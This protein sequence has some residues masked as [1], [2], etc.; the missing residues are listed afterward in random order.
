MEDNKRRERVG[1]DEVDELD[2]AQLIKYSKVNFKKIEFC[3]RSN[4][5]LERL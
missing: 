1:Q 3:P 4:G 5:S 2:R